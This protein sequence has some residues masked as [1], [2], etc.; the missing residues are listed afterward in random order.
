MKRFRFSAAMTG[1][2]SATLMAGCS[3]PPPPP[4]TL[5]PPPV[6]QPTTS[7]ARSVL[8]RYRY[9]A[10]QAAMTMGCSGPNQS[11]PEAKLIHQQNGLEWYEVECGNKVQRLRCDV[12]ACIPIR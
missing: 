6:T 7:H 12:G 2:I 9:E 8:T 1:L 4:V 5:P 3:H 11:R 10:E